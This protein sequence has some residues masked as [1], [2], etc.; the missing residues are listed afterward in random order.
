[1]PSK[2]LSD[3]DAKTVLRGW[4]LCPGTKLMPGSQWLRAQPPDG[5]TVGPRLIRP[6][7]TEFTAHTQPDG[8]WVSFLRRQG[9]AR[10][11]A[12]SV[13]AVEVSRTAQNLADKRS[14]YAPG[15]AALLVSVTRGWLLGD[16]PR[17]NS[18]TR[19]R[20]EL[21]DVFD[22][23]PTE[24]LFLPVRSVRVLFAV[25]NDGS[26][27]YQQLRG[28]LALEAHEYLAPHSAL[29]HTNP[30]LREL[31]SRILAPHIL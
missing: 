28:A 23:E 10:P 16:V 7:S 6:A 4:P 18:G 22:D 24:D 2:R 27:L 25:P 31:V 19:P 26:R 1:M 8:L 29:S 3:G 13:F 17:P 11:D 9:Y 14:R 15:H 20:W 5:S 30:N 21:A 12:V